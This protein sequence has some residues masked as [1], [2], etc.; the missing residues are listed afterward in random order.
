MGDC[1]VEVLDCKV[2]EE[3]RRW[4]VVDDKVEEGDEEVVYDKV[5]EEEG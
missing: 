1:K 3:M 4:V 2:E 5:E